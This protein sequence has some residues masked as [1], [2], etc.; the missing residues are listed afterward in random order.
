MPKTQALLHKTTKDGRRFDA[1]LGLSPERWRR[2]KEQTMSR[3]PGLEQAEPNLTASAAAGPASSA[4]GRFQ[5][6]ICA[7]LF[8]DCLNNYMDRQVL[9]LLKPDLS[10]LFGWTETDYGRITIAFQTA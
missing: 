10:K 1:N 9:G 3:I 7:M 8:S 4:V 5:W 6:V 2:V